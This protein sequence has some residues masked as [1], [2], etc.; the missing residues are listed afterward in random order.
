MFYKSYFEHVSVYCFDSNQRLKLIMVIVCFILQQKLTI[1]FLR[2]L[3][4]GEQR[5]LSNQLFA[6][7]LLI[8]PGTQNKI[9]TLFKVWKY[10][11]EFNKQKWSKCFVL[12]AEESVRR[13]DFIIACKWCKTENSKQQIHKVELIFKARS[14]E[15]F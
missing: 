13:D 9:E 15:L 5:L 10:P 8:Q 6:W 2:K 7:P 1:L 3:F 14:D 4:S 12:R 11:S